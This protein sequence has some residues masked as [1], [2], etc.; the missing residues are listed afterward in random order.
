VTIQNILCDR[1]KKR[2]DTE[3]VKTKGMAGQKAIV[4]ADVTQTTY[5]NGN[6]N[7][8]L[9]TDTLIILL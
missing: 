6:G 5:T 8:I 9:T 3:I 1:K 4:I 7:T 2:Y